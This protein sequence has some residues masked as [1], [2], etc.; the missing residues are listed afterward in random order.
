M[1]DVQVLYAEFGET[2]EDRFVIRT[3]QP[4]FGPFGAMFDALR[5]CGQL[6]VVAK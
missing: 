6:A 4:V 1:G 3:V 2:G 5:Q